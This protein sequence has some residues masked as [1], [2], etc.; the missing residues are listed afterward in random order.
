MG[1]GHSISPKRGNL[2]AVAGRQHGQSL[3]A[4]DR[5][6]LALYWG[7]VLS[8]AWLVVDGAGFGLVDDHVFFEEH[9]RHG[10][11]RLFWGNEAARFCPLNG[12]EFLILREL[13]FLSA[14]LFYAIQACKILVCAG[15]ILGIFR[16]FGAPLVWACA[17]GLLCLTSSAFLVSASRLFIPEM[18][19]FM[20][21]LVMLFVVS[22]G[23]G[24]CLGWRL[25]A[26]VA[27]GTIALYYKEPGVVALAALGAMLTLLS[28]MKGDREWRSYAKSILAMVPVYLLLYY[29]FAY[30]YRGQK[31]YIADHQ[32]S[33]G[34]VLIY[35]IKNDTFYIISIVV[36]SAFVVKMWRGKNVCVISAACVISSLAYASVFAALK[37]VSSWYLLP[38]YAFLL[39][40]LGRFMAY[41]EQSANKFYRAIFFIFVCALGTNSMLGGAYHLSFNKAVQKGMDPFFEYLERYSSSIASAPTVIVLPRIQKNSEIAWTLETV[42]RAKG[43][44]RIYNFRYVEHK[45]FGKYLVSCDGL[46]LLTPYT[47]VSDAEKEGL[48]TC[49][50]QLFS[51]PESMTDNSSSGLWPSLWVSPLSYRAF[52]EDWKRLWGNF[53]LL[54]GSFTGCAEQFDWSMLKFEAD[55]NGLKVCPMGMGRFILRVTNTS[56]KEFVRSQVML[57]NPVRIVF[58]YARGGEPLHPAGYRDLPERLKPGESVALEASF[59]VSTFSPAALGGYLGTLS[60]NNLHLVW[61]E[62]IFTGHFK[63]DLRACVPGG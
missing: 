20:L 57:G 5:L 8:L 53:V 40:A 3:G 47:M 29:F 62:P 52:M 25:W 31:T 55:V 1:Y 12:R 63:P 9:L 58:G 44:D 49:Y 61:H 39:P 2:L 37:I 48:K 18:T 6:I 13:G 34:D 16:R 36:L 23:S 60:N 46:M 43:L 10:H 54:E 27:A 41:T 21:F 24:K 32:Q 35:Y 26:S 17:A 30:S 59:C 7:A 11:W 38:A 4:A 28:C 14:P 15:C 42:L 22:G 51:S 19:S 45:D 50:S 33:F 56:G